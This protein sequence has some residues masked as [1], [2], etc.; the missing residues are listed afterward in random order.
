VTRQQHGGAVGD[1]L[2]DE[3]RRLALQQRV[4]PARRLVQ[5]EQVGARGEGEHQPDLLLVALRQ[6]ADPAVQ[7]EVEPVGEAT[8]RGT[9]ERRP[10]Q[11]VAAY[12]VVPVQPRWQHQL[13]GQV[14]RPSPDLD[15]VAHAVEPEDGDRAT[16]RAEEVEQRPHE[17][18]LAGTVGADEP[19]DL[20]GG[21]GEVDVDDAAMPP[22]G[23]RQSPRLDR[24]RLHT[25]ECAA[26]GVMSGSFGPGR[27]TRRGYF[28]WTMRTM[29][30]IACGI[31]V[32]G[33]GKKH[34]WTYSPAGTS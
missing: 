13:A 32:F 12:D 16:R 23:L 28:R 17:R 26:P 2:R 8:D 6:I 22:V 7:V 25:V 1:P 34:I 9:V 4:E 27:H 3:R 21:D 18:R 11:R 5:H 14:R 19:D 10:R 29:P 30:I 33:S 24:H 15:R 20:A 31:P